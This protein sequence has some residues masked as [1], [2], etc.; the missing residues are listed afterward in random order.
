MSKR[1]KKLRTIRDLVF[2]DRNANRGT[3][4]GRALVN[5]SLEK[6]GAGRSV[7]ADAQGKLIAGNKTVEQ[8]L[9]RGAK[10]IV[11]PSRGEALVVH[12]RLDLDMDRDPEAREL[13]V[14]DNRSGQLGLEWDAA[15]LEEL[16]RDGADLGSMFTVEELEELAGSIEAAAGLGA[17]AGSLSERFLIPPFSVLDARQGY[18]QERKRAWL[19]LGIQSELGRGG[20]QGSTPSHNPQTRKGADGLLQSKGKDGVWRNLRQGSSTSC[21]TKW[22]ELKGVR[23]RKVSAAPGGGLMPAMKLRKG[24][25]VRGDGRGREIKR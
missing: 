3:D 17:S 8:A 6:Y 20:G 4:R 18:W 19:A 24:K 12:Q 5:H 1:P 13:A 14:A 25:T 22:E 16:A 11:V 21:S 2:D 7:L 15:M 23:Q 10:I 9:A